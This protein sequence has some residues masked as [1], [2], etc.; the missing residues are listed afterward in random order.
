MIKKIRNILLTIGIIASM[1]VIASPMVGAVDVFGGC[2]GATDTAVCKNSGDSIGT[3]IK[4][5]VNLLL[6]V[7][8][9]VA[10]VMIIVSGIYFTISSGDPAAL[11]KA[12]STLLYSVVGLLVAIMSFAIVNFVLTQFKF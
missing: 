1:G 5:G 7:L 3:I 9:A 10:V 2:D 6:Y 12:K 11:T 4:N 8:S